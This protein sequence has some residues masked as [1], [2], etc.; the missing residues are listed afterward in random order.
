MATERKYL[1]LEKLGLYDEKIKKVIT[2]GDAAALASANSYADSLASNYDAAGAASTAEANAKSYTDAE[3]AKANTAASTAQAA[4]EAADAKAVAADGKAVAAQTDVDNLEA[5]VGTIPTVEGEETPANIVAYIQKKTSG[6]ATSDNLAELTDRVAQAETDIDNIEKD[7]LKAADK[8]ELEGKITSAQ[9]AADNA[10][11]AV[12]TL[13]GT[14]STDKAA[15]EA[16]IALKAD[17]TALNA[18]SDV[19]NAAVAKADYDVKVKALEDEDARI[20][21]LVTAE[22]A[23]AREEEGKLDARLDKVEAFF[24]GAAEDGEGLQNA[25]DTLVEIQTY[26]DTHGEAAAKMVDDI[27][28]NKKAIEDHAAT[29]HNFAA[30]DSALKTELEGKINAKADSSVVEGVTG[31]VGTLETEMDAVEGRATTLEGKMTAVEGAVATKVEQEAYNTKV[32]ALEGADAD[33]DERLQEVEAMLGDGDNTV[34]ELIATAKQE[35]IDAAAT[36]ATTKANAAKDAAITK[37]N[38]LNTAM[39][40]R[41]EALEEI[42]HEHANKELLDTYT[43]TEAD[44]KDAVAKKHAHAANM[45]EVTPDQVEAWNKVSEKATQTALQAEIDRATAKENELSAAIAAFVEISEEDI[46]KLFQS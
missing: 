1:S 6:I 5:Y 21:G 40:T 26:V 4:A 36:D 45:V 34:T 23:K 8:T 9:T 41:V 43:Q 25:L 46:N 13:S 17:K 44:L 27:A 3:V 38:E 33:L 39:N 2:D 15:L 32:A 37:A 28:A 35:A 30:A 22:A 11:N 18:V 10:Q 24:E 12:D 29:D 19:A 14:H 16:A 7:Y 20:E 42:D 31:R